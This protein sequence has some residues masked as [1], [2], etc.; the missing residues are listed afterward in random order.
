MSIVAILVDGGFYQ[1]RA[2]CLWGSS[3]Q[4]ID[5]I[6]DEIKKRPETIIEDLKNKMAKKKC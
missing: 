5:F 1:R 4:A 3:I 6:V 2:Q